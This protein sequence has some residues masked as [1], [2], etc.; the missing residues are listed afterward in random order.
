MIELSHIDAT[1]SK[2][3]RELVDTTHIRTV[4]GAHPRILSQKLDLNALE[5]SKRKDAVRKLEPMIDEATEMRAERFIVLSGTDPGPTK[6]KS[7]G[8]ALIQ[9]LLELCSYA[10]ESGIDIALE[11]FDRDV[12]KRCLIGP[13]QEAL[14]ISEAVKEE[15]PSFGLTYDMAHGTLLAE[16]PRKSLHLL[17][18]HLVHVH[19]G[20]CVRNRGCVAYGDQHP[21]FGVTGGENDVA[22]LTR[23]LRV[24]REIDYIP[25][26]PQ[27][28]SPVIGFEL[29]PL[30]GEKPEAVIANGKRTWQKAW[31]LL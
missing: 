9:S 5:E 13:S 2:Q 16:D 3:V 4:F 10:K 1:F 12:E 15:F 29:K 24:L 20:N 8:E 18:E 25:G 26:N 11:T 27:E 14:C 23:F 7:A 30:P 19:I 22:Q 31:S 28:V 21:R 17:K 6:R